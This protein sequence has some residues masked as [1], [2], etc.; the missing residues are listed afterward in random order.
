M[1]RSCVIFKEQHFHAFAALG[2]MWRLTQDKLGQIGM[3]L[4]I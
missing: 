3:Q 1:A 4:M 2:M